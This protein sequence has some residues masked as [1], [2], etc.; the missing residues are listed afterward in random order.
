MHFIAIT[1]ATFTLF[2]LMCSCYGHTASVVITLFL[3]HNRSGYFTD[4]QECSYALY[5]LKAATTI[6]LGYWHRNKSCQRSVSIKHYSGCG[7]TIFNDRVVSLFTLT[8]NEFYIFYQSNGESRLYN[9]LTY[10]YSAFWSP[11]NIRFYPQN[12]VKPNT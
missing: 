12:T 10:K 1:L 4:W 5:D 11:K 3:V 7:C 2:Y 8:A 6:H 9:Y